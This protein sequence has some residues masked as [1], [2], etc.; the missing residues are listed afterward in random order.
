MKPPSTPP[1]LTDWYPPSI[2]P[3]RVGVYQRDMR[4]TGNGQYSHW[5]G[6][7]WGGWGGSIEIAA[8][9]AGGISSVQD[10]NWR[11]LAKK[12]RKS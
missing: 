1:R 2:K 5:D 9:N 8:R 4:G 3:A 6:M 12:P 10:A 7:F 11:G